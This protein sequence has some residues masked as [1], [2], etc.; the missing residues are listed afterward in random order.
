MAYADPQ[1]PRNREAKLRHYYSNKEA[2]Y[3]RSKKQRE[4]IRTF[5]QAVKSYPCL[6]C[7]VTYPY[8]VM[9]FDHRP[10]EVKVLTPAR[11]VN[12]GSWKKVV[13]EIM[14]CDVVCAN[15]HAERTHQ[16]MLR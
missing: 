1:D 5:L 16:R 6:D 3:E 11:L 12:C 4:E 10:D 14:K 7:G 8:Y 13:D 9:Q 2:Y 15:C